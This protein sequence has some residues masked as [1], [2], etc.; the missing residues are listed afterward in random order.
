MQTTRRHPIAVRRTVDTQL[1]QR[2]LT[3]V[4]NA[5]FITDNRGYIAWVNDA[6]TRLSGYPATEAIGRAPSFLNSGK[7]DSSFYHELWRTILAGNVWRGEVVER[8]KDGGYYTVDQV[9]TPLRDEDGVVTHFV[10]V[11][12]DITQRKQEGE[13]ERYLAYHDA[14]TGLPNRALFS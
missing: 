3:S 9:I 2:A 10:A 12:H 14:L 7:Q 4:A 5:I 1:L 13:R 8:H 11:H 6:F